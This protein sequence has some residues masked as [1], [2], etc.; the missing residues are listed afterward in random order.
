MPK[1][2]D[3]FYSVKAILDAN[4]N[5]LMLLDLRFSVWTLGIAAGTFLAA[6]Y[7]MNLKNFIEESDLG[8]WGI[9]GISAAASVFVIMYGVGRL[10]RVQ[11]VSMW[12]GAHSAPAPASRMML[13]TAPQDATLKEL[14]AELR[15]EERSGMW[16]LG[17]KT[18]AQAERIRRLNE[19]VKEQS[20]HPQ[21]PLWAKAYASRQMARKEPDA[22]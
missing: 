14:Q 17:W 10:R 9:S 2:T 8:F 22:Q 5:A 3:N 7:G 13:G 1:N 21:G 15:N 20:H 4:R 18:V 11:R 12:G 19:K 16:G 6:L